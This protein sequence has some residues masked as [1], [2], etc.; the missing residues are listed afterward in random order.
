MVRE[1]IWSE[2]AAFER[3]EILNW[4]RKLMFPMSGLG[5]SMFI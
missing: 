5:W 2:K 3:K 1:I 4:G